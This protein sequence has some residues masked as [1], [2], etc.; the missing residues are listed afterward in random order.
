LQGNGESTDKTPHFVDKVFSS[1]NDPIAGGLQATKLAQLQA[2]LPSIHH[3]S[4]DLENLAFQNFEEQFSSLMS[5]LLFQI[6][7]VIIIIT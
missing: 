4:F 3:E 5:L 6:M 1:I 2:P 7:Q